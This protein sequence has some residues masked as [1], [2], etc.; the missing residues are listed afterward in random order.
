MP[1]DAICLT[2]LLTELRP[3]LVGARVDKIQQPQK[4][5]LLL[6]LR[7]KEQGGKLL[8]TAGTGSARIHLTGRSF[9][10]PQSPPMFCMLLR[11]HLTGARLAA[12]EQPPLERVARLVFDT[13]NELGEPSRKT[14]VL[15]LLGKNCNLILVDA[16]DIIL[17][18]L[19][20]VDEDMSRTRRILP[21]LRYRLPEA[22][23]KQN[24]LE[25]AVDDIQPDKLLDTF[26]GLSPLICRELADRT[27]PQIVDFFTAIRAGVWA[28]YELSDESGP[29]D[30]SYTP[31]R[32]YQSAKAASFSAL[33]DNFYETRDRTERHRGQTGTLL[34]TVTNL[35]DRTARKLEAQRQE[36]AEAENRD[37]FREQGDLI[38]ANL[39]TIK[40]GQAALTAQ[41]F[42]DPDGGEITIPLDTRKTPQQ[43][44]AAYYK[45][46]TKA[47]TAE[48]HLAEQI[49]KGEGELD[50]L[51]SV[52][53]AIARAE[54][55]GDVAQIREELVEVGV[56]RA[57]TG[58]KKQKP[59]P[60]KPLQ[61]VSS[62][63]VTIYAGK[64]NLQNDKL[65]FKTA[66]RHDTWLH[67]QKIHGSHVIV[68]TGGGEPDAQ[69][70]E[71]A[72]AIAAWYSQGRAGGRVPVDYTLVK[73]VKK[74]S[75][76]KPG[77][78]H[79][80]N[81]KTIVATP[82]EVLMKRLQQ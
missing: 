70:L 40:K 42:Y 60:S 73:H 19:R 10:N 54:T 33:L 79:Y 55:T 12:I 1:L 62:T 56:L 35:R 47:K 80:V 36:Q 3:E 68:A 32:K 67:A 39:H 13:Y 58:G 57:Q 27:P 59:L 2:A 46:Y 18:A 43:N 26:N 45:R 48:K 25:A 11:K 8:L 49:A 21:G 23:G 20:R 38:T 37:R 29:V 51:S 77:A 31:I 74:P 64:N 14:L 34:K 61:F 4:D 41:N 44:A 63:G 78:A 72:A 5:K 65:T 75:G 24:P 15:E 71:E 6:T 22:Q 50:Y 30:F 52:L 7:G 66:N 53:E 28:P 16:D 76:G 82:D 81:Y 69:T 17:D 9:E